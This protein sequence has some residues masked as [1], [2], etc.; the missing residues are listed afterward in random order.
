[1]PRAMRRSATAPSSTIG[2]ELLIAAYGQWFLSGRTTNV[3]RHRTSGPAVKKPAGI[4]IGGLALL[5]LLPFV[6]LLGISAAAASAACSGSGGRDVDTQAVAGQVEA[7]LSGRGPAKVRVPGLDDPVDQ[8]PNAKAV[9]ATG[10]AMR[11]PSRGQIV[12]LATALQESGL[13]NLAYGDRDSLGLFQQRPSEGWGTAAEVMDPGHASAEFYAALRRVPG[14]EALTIGQA[15]QAVQRS[16]YPDAY[17]KW[18]PLATALQTAIEPLLTTAGRAA[19]GHAAQSAT[20][21]S[22][23]CADGLDGPAPDGALPAGYVVPSDAPAQAQIAVRWA[24]NQLG[25]P[26]QW[27]GRCTDPHG[28]DP[29]G[30]CD[31]SSL[32]QQSYRQAGITLP[33]TTYEQVTTGKP[34]SVRA[35]RPGDLVFT[36]GSATRPEHV[37]MYIGSGLVVHA[38]H[39]SA[40]VRV[41]PLSSWIPQILA[42]RRVL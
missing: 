5:A 12:A 25:T 31:C 26:Y 35:L 18:V 9:V 7:I 28:P 8:V 39:S 23:T 32:V 29:M 13:R 38:P 27:G 11:I 20:S 6:T 3:D 24:L 15:A 37:G 4:L 41:E 34:A 40:E 14:W 19:T 1:M 22:A 21:H 16:A 42:A 36:E 33:R 30:R 10:L 2:E 17:E